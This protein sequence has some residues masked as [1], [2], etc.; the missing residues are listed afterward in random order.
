MVVLINIAANII[1]D[2]CS[3]WLRYC[4]INILWIRISFLV[5][6]PPSL[7][8]VGRSILL[9]WFRKMKYLRSLSIHTQIKNLGLTERYLHTRPLKSPLLTSSI[10]ERWAMGGRFVDVLTTPMKL[11]PILFNSSQQPTEAKCE[12][13]HT[14]RFLLVHGATNV[15][16]TC[17]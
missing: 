2:M 15:L 6:F 9:A 12:S 13:A 11:R 4:Q 5:H 16:K 17:V 14:I 8:G 1:V 3:L 7:P 10:C